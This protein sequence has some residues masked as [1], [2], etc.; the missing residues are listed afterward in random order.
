[1]TYEPICPVITKLLPDGRECHDPAGRVCL[2]QQCVT[3]QTWAMLMLQ[4]RLWRCWRPAFDRIVTLSSA[5]KARLE[6]E[7]IAPIEVI[8]NG[9]PER[10]MR[11]P[12]S[13][14][15]TVAF[16]GRLVRAK[17]VD[18]LLHALSM[19]LPEVPDVRLLIAGQGEAR[20]ELEGLAQSL[21]LGSH[22]D[23]LGHV[24][25]SDMEHAF[26]R[27]WVQVVPSR[28]AEPFGNVA[29][30]GLMRG[31]AVIASAMGGLSEIVADGETGSLVPPD[32][33]EALAAALRPLLTN[34]ATAERMGAAGRMRALTYFNEATRTDRFEALYRD[35]IANRT[36]AHG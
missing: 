21:G 31:T 12:L 14:P 20:S 36:T 7:G 5:T 24:S 35:M 29:A 19:L 22:I 27:A 25:R 30:E 34:R 9:V 3:P 2:R 26:E 4:Q 6:A 18:V 23:W 33:V 28:W 1:V 15:P 13:A 10:P 11:P 32:S 8:H 17:G 16:A